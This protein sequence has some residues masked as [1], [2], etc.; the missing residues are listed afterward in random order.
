[1]REVNKINDCL[2]LFE[3]DDRSFGKG[4][5]NRSLTHY[6]NTMSFSEIAGKLS[7]ARALSRRAKQSGDQSL[8]QAATKI[9][10]DQVKQVIK[11]KVKQAI[12][13][14][15][16]EALIAAAPY[17]AIAIGCL[18]VVVFIYYCAEN[19]TECVNMVGDVL[20]ELFKSLF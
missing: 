13:R 7:S 15:I 19:K 14:A 2:S 5:N 20:W 4:E 3:V 17:I 6:Y 16:I 9:A 10:K 18:I 1:M 12:T 11:E 8:A